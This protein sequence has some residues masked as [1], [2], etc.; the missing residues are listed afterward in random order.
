[1]QSQM[2]IP[3]SITNDSCLRYKER[4][5]FSFFLLLRTLEEEKLE[6]TVVLIRKTTKLIDGNT[7]CKIFVRLIR[8]NWA[9]KIA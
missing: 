4:V 2:T 6:G 8:N 1:M 5:S 7:F 3:V 9:V